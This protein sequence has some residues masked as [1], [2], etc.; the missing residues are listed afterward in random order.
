MH[1]PIGQRSAL[2]TYE[3]TY[4]LIIQC[5]L[6]C[7]YLP[8]RMGQFLCKKVTNYGLGLW[9]LGQLGTVWLGLRFTASVTIRVSVSSIGLKAGR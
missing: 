9:T 2:H 1:Q 5:R 3:I 6:S 8:L 4:F 7:L